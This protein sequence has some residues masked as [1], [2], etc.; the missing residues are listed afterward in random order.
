[1]FKKYVVTSFCMVFFLST[2]SNS[3]QMD[4]NN[5]DLAN[6]DYVAQAYQNLFAL[7]SYSVISE[8]TITQ[9]LTDGSL[10]GAIL[11]NLDMTAS[12]S[13]YINRENGQITTYQM[14]SQQEV[15]M[16]ITGGAGFFW[17]LTLENIISDDSYYARATDIT[18]TP[19]INAPIGWLDLTTTSLA[20]ELSRV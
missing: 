14:I 5:K 19:F 6:I 20:L 12:S 3:A 10:D 4:F 7:N 17:T 8:T 13:E 15:E 16:L 9:E 11:T 2:I 18:G 1:M